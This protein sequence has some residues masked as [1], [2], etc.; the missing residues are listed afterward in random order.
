MATRRKIIGKSCPRGFCIGY[1]TGTVFRVNLNTEIKVILIL[2]C[3]KHVT[4][5]ILKGVMWS[6]VTSL[7]EQ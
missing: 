4:L 6:L 7:R 3:Y 5:S 2:H 1:H